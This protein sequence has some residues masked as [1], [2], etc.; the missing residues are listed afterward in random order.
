MAVSQTPSHHHRKLPAHSTLLSGRNPP[1][2]VGFQSDRL[3]IWYNNSTESWTDPVPH[4]HLE[5]DEIFVVLRG[6]LVVEVEGKR[7]TVG[8]GEFCAFPM[9]SLHSIV[10]VHLPVESLMIRAPSVDDKVGADG[11]RL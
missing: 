3:Q 11:S 4:A 2:D 1:N 5:S 8:P 6:T 9:G 7:I 10:E